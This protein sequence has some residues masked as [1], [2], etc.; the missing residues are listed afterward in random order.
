METTEN[1]LYILTKNGVALSV[2]QHVLLWIAH[3]LSVTGIRRCNL[4]GYFEQISQSDFKD[5]FLLLTTDVQSA[6][7]SFGYTGS[8]EIS[9][10]IE[11]TSGGQVVKHEVKQSQKNYRYSIWRL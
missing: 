6:I 2:Q 11:V 4:I 9:N 3:P 8:G 5:L 10:G 7:T 1:I